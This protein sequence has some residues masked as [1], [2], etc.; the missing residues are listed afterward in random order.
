M[1]KDAWGFLLLMSFTFFIFFDEL[2]LREKF[3][4]IILFFKSLC[5][6][7]L[8]SHKV[9]KQSRRYQ[10]LNI[11]NQEISFKLQL[12]SASITKCDD[13]WREI[14]DEIYPTELTINFANMRT[15]DV[16]EHMRAIY[17]KHGTSAEWMKYS[18]CKILLDF[19]QKNDC[20]RFKKFT[21]PLIKIV[22]HDIDQLYKNNAP[23]ENI[24]K[25]VEE[26]PSV[27]VSGLVAYEQQ[28]LTFIRNSDQY[29]YINIFS[30]LLAQIQTLKKIMQFKG[31]NYLTGL[32]K[33]EYRI[34]NSIKK[35]K[36]FLNLQKLES[37]INP[38]EFKILDENLR[39]YLKNSVQTLKKVNQDYMSSDVNDLDIA[40]RASLISEDGKLEYYRK[41]I[42]M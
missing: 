8:L 36:A 35:Y 12:L 20:K 13:N 15:T 16:C 5:V 38:A 28:F 24:Q 6:F 27:D 19:D 29:E 37:A 41:N 22:E 25:V 10:K 32:G 33:I 4:S 21:I 42:S 26:Q 2:D 39:T 17:Y 1:N 3:E 23:K 31:T 34:E 7:P 30:E 9:K 11:E 18:L 40:I 14:L